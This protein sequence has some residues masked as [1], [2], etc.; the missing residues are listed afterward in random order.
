MM[1]KKVPL[2][3][4]EAEKIC[5]SVTQDTFHETRTLSTGMAFCQLLRSS[6]IPDSLPSRIDSPRWIRW[7]S[8]LN[9]AF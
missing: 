7:N 2:G 9:F 3:A 8:G 4:W 1:C 5:I 6:R